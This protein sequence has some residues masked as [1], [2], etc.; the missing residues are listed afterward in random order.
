MNVSTAFVPS[1]VSASAGL[2]PWSVVRRWWSRS[3]H[4]E[5]AVIALAMNPIGCPLSAG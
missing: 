3:D 5:R 2:C 4:D 1:M